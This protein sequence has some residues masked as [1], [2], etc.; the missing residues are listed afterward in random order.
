M[1]SD[2]RRKRDKDDKDKKVK[3]KMDDRQKRSA[4]SSIRFTYSK[5]KDIY[6]SVTPEGETWLL[7]YSCIS[8]FLHLRNIHAMLLQ[9]SM[10]KCTSIRIA[11]IPA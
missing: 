5:L 11:R 10:D 1:E 4:V 7:Y 6:S 8:C 2:V 9:Y 3:H